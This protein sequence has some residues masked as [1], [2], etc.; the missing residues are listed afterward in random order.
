MATHEYKGGR[1][2]PE[3]TA[4]LKAGFADTLIER[5]R[6]GVKNFPTKLVPMERGMCVDCGRPKAAHTSF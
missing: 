4:A 1:Y 6:R 3:N 5:Q 2:R